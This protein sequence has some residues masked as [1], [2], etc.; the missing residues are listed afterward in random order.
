MPESNPLLITLSVDTKSQLFFNHLRQKHFPPNINYLDAHLMLFHNL[1][2]GEEK[3][4]TDLEV[5]AAQTGPFT[6]EVTD[7]VCIGRGVAY[8]VVSP[9]LS[10]LHRQF[11][12]KWQQWLI[13]QDTQTLWP[14]ITIQN[15]VDHFA[16]K[17]LANELGKDFEPFEETATG[18]QLWEYLAGPW[19][20]LRQFDF[21]Q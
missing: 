14:H 2:A 18:F 19:K 6:M 10:A 4:L 15:K 7:V 20:F 8:K 9:H 5:M 17:E 3:I 13:P 11:Q 21:Q 1:P 12:Q 16:A